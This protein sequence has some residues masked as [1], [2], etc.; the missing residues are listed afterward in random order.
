MTVSFRRIHIVTARSPAD[1]LQRFK[2]ALTENGNARKQA[3]RG[4]L[5]SHRRVH[6]M[7]NARSQFGNPFVPNMA[8]K[9]ICRNCKNPEPNIVEEFGKGD[10]VCGD[11]GLILG[12]RV[13]DTRSEWR[14]S[15]VEKSIYPLPAIDVCWR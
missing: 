10:L 5:P 13:V 4:T 9:L 3:F 14:V 2:P 1:I 7:A 12:D 6:A 11:C 15:V 8:V